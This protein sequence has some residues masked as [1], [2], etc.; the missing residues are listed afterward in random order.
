MTN[1]P[2]LESRVKDI[3]EL[4]SNEVTL[5]VRL[6]DRDHGWLELWEAGL[7]LSDLRLE[8]STC[9]DLSHRCLPRVGS[10]TVREAESEDREQR[11]DRS[12]KKKSAITLAAQWTEQRL[13]SVV[14]RDD[15]S[16]MDEKPRWTLRSPELATQLVSQLREALDQLCELEFLIRE[17][18]ATSRSIRSARVLLRIEEL[19]DTLV[20]NNRDTHLSDH[21]ETRRAFE[22]VHEARS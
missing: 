13:R 12:E 19:S 1:T 10:L 7:R 2:S 22:L 16:A 9:L 21:E 11:E 20:K 5:I 17:S 6:C 8:L 18:I 3:L 14:Q 15:E 4:I